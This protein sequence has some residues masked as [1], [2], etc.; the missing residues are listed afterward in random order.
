MMQPAT[1]S[2]R[3]L[4]N[5]ELTLW[6]HVAQ[7]RRVVLWSVVAVFVC[8]SVVHYFRND[9]IAFIIRPLHGAPLQYLSPLDPLVFIL[10]IDFVGGLVLALPF[11]VW[12]WYRFVAPALPTFRKMTVFFRLLFPLL[13]A[14]AAACYAYY[15][16]IPLTLNVLTS[17]TVPGVT[18]SFTAENYLSFFITA[19]LML[20]IV[21]EMPVV[22]VIL[23]RLGLLH[24]STLA[25]KR[26]YVYVGLLI[27]VAAITPTTDIVSL[28]LILLPTYAVF[29]VGLI[30]ARMVGN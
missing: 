18:V 1:P 3:P 15:V 14:G 10:T 11:I 29:E 5:D 21:F 6:E 20:M 7:L 30:G 26:K 17:F 16:A 24:A 25:K 8:G 22:M 4:T 12:Q 23:A 27:A 19:L 2:K 28:M 13:L 9:V